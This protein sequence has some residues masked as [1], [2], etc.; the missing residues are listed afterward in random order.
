M[1]FSCADDII[2]PVLHGI[3]FDPSDSAPALLAV[4]VAGVVWRRHRADRRARL[5][6][7]LAVAELAFGLPLALV[8]ANL[9]DGRAAV[10]AVQ[11]LVL[12]GGLLSTVV[13]LHF[14]LSFP[15]ARP[16][17]RGRRM[18]AVYA[19]A[20]LMGAAFFLIGLLA[21]SRATA[22]P[23]PLD[24]AMLALGATVVAAALAACLAIYRGY[25]EMTADAR[26]RYRV[27]VLGVL[28]GMI[29]G[30]VV[31][32]MIAVIFGTSIGMDRRYVVWIANVLA[33][34][35]ELLLPLFFFMAAVKYRLLEHHS[36]D[37][38]AKL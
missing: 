12:A 8:A 38:V 10:A 5:F 20:V 7:A 11:A 35:A 28:A 3:G 1:L 32:L 25:R 17:L 21:P 14:G 2:E 6:L 16:A 23:D 9:P 31:D 36:Q 29:A 30:L 37:Y 26:R 18:R 4:V 33:T 22:G 13:F 24:W 19:L 34:A 27:P 15:H